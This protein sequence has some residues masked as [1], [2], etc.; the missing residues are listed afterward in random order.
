MGSS[1]WGRSSRAATR[2]CWPAG[3]RP[4][5]FKEVDTHGAAVLVPAAE[6]REDGNPL[7]SYGGVIRLVPNRA[8]LLQAIEVAGYREPR[9]LE[10]PAHLDPQYVEG[11]RGIAFART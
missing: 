7:A 5:F 1:W 11:H 4:E 2:R 8:A 6:Q 9:L 3:G 10:A